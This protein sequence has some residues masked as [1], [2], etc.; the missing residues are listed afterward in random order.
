[1]IL[2]EIQSN[3]SSQ[4]F[5]VI[6]I[7]SNL[8]Y[9]SDFLFLSFENTAFTIVESVGCNC[10]T[11]GFTYIVV[12]DS[13]VQPVVPRALSNLSGLSTFGMFNHADSC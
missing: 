6:N 8:R 5:V 2:E 9:G 1:M 7:F 12:H 4:N 10:P 11:L 3:K 13:V